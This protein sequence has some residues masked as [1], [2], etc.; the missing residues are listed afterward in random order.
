[1]RPHWE[2]YTVIGFIVKVVLSLLYGN[3]F[4]FLKRVKP[5]FLEGGPAIKIKKG[6]A[7]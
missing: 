5:L 3:D 4:A 1:M 7:I 6:S 2:A